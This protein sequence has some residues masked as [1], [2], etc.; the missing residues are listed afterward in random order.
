MIRFLS[1]GEGSRGW[2][3]EASRDVRGVEGGTA[4][5]LEGI[6]LV[7][8]TLALSRSIH[9][10]RERGFLVGPL[11]VVSLV[12]VYTVRNWH[13]GDERLEAKGEELIRCDLCGRPML[14]IQCKLRCSNC[15]YIRDCSDP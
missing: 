4:R 8:L 6:G 10:R 12:G 9:P 15:G 7:P 11:L 1:W 2:D 5:L 14:G 13:G 3:G